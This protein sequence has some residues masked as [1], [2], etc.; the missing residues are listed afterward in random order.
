VAHRVYLPPSGGPFFCAICKYY[1]PA[2]QGC[3]QKDVIA[4]LG[5]RGDGQAQVAAFGCSDFFER[6]D[7]LLTARI[8]EQWKK[9]YDAR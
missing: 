6:G 3:K 5:D 7:V 2:R 4:A 8:L 1:T 9:A